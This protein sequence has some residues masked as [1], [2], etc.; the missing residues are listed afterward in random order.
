MIFCHEH[1]QIIDGT[2]CYVQLSDDLTHSVA[3][4]VTIFAASSCPRV[5]PYQDTG[6]YVTD[7][8]FMYRTDAGELLMIWSSFIDNQYAEMLVRF[9]G[10]E[11]GLD[12]TH[13]PALADNDSGHGML[14]KAKDKLYLTVH[15]PNTMECEHPV[16]IE[17][18]DLGN[19]I[20]VKNKQTE[21]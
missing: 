20:R 13:L 7:G 6:H 8:P 12:Y 4:P 14:F 19:T 3:E 11:L 2:I 16:F 9:E 15:Y 21:E 5:T 10:G 17:L 18:E 1:S